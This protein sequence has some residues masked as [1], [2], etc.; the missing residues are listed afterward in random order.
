MEK[1]KKEKLPDSKQVDCAYRVRGNDGI[2]LS[3]GLEQRLS[4]LLQQYSY[5]TFLYLGNKCSLG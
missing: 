4:Y 2:H 5:S 1:K 3:E